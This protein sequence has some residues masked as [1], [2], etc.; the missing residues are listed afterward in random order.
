MPDV[1][2]RIAIVDDDPSVRRA[3]GRLLRAH[4]YAVETHDSGAALLAAMGA[5]PPACLIVDQQMPDL[6]GLDLHARLVASGTVIPTI[7][8]TAHEASEHRLRCAAAGI[9]AYLVKPLDRLVVT[10]AIEHALG[11]AA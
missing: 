5:E 4:G 6:T 1:V 11:K 3:L 9:V 10:A 7:V 8:I 2:V